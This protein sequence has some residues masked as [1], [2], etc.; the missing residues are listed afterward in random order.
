MQ[1]PYTQHYRAVNTA[2]PELICRVRTQSLQ[3]LAFHILK[4]QLNMIPFRWSGEA[5]PVQQVWPRPI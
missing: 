4:D 1:W 5:I 3:S 2:Q